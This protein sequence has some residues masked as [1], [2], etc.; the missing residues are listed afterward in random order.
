MTASDERREALLDALNSR[1]LV[2]D[3]A[4]GT[5][6]QQRHLTAADFGGAALEGCN[7][8]LVKT[9]PDVV[10]GIHRAYLE[11][12]ADIIE[13]NSFNGTK[14]DLV[15]YGVDGESYQLMVTAARLARQAADEF[16]TSRKPRFVAGSMGPTRK[17]ITISRT[18]TFDHLQQ[19]YYDLAKPLVEGG[20]DILLLETCQ[21]TRNI[22]AGLLAIRRL[23]R[24]LGRPIPVMV[25]GTIETMGTMLAGQTADAFYASIEHADLL[26]VGLN[27]GTGPEFMTDHLRTLSE[28]ASTRVSCYPNAG[29]P[30]VEG[31]YNETPQSFAEQLERFV[32]HGWLNLVGGCCGTTAAHIKTVAQMVEGRK[33]RAV[34]PPSHRAYYSGIE[35]VEAEDS[36]RPLIVGE[37]TN[38]IGSRLFKNMVA[39]EK[40]EEATEIARWQVKN[41]A[42]VVDVCLQST[43]RDE[44]KDIPPFYEKL[45]RKT[46]APVMIDTTDPRAIELALT[47][48]RH[49]RC[50]RQ[51]VRP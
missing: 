24:E 30:N 31:E 15:D 16:S 3:G 35:L 6:L 17:S 18:I 11:A 42:H 33:P 46:K 40:W 50:R 14:S 7:E 34:K 13:T 38:M 48:L 28:M 29:L 5:M 9:R 22:K 10:L 1:I 49:H 39:E 32:A 12:G 27:C 23:M 21:D 2:I 19:D 25:S 37:R 51:A 26:S 8:H 44:I 45:I 4:M 36:N 20:A 43:E 41:G 47:S